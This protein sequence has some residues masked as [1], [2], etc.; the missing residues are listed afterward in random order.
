MIGDAA[1]GKTKLAKSISDIAIKYRYTAGVRASKAGMTAMVVKDDFLGTWGVEAGAIVLANGG[2]CV[3]DE[4]DKMT[5]ED[6]EALYEQM[7]DQQF[8]IDKAN[9]HATLIAKTSLLAIANWKGQR[10]NPN[11]DIY[12]QINMP[13]PLI[14]RFVLYYCQQ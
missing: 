10:F 14:S 4:L 12:S 6:R 7:E 3:A 13:G 1:T 5:T 8:T 9:I 11:E 2:I